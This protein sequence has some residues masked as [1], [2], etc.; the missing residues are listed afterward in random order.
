MYREIFME[1]IK[2]GWESLGWNVWVLVINFFLLENVCLINGVFEVG[3][4][5]YGR[6]C[7]VEWVF[8]Y[9]I[10]G[11]R[12]KNVICFCGFMFYGE[13]SGLIECIRVN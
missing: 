3:K 9:L 13:W 7:Y 4:E 12:W 10:E 6:N 5:N 2:F 11:L 8:V 1:N